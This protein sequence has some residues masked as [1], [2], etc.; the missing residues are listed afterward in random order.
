LVN[1]NK[2]AHFRISKSNRSHFE[3]ASRNSRV[4]KNSDQENPPV[5]T[6]AKSNEHKAPREQN[7]YKTRLEF[8]QGNVEGCTDLLPQC[9]TGSRTLLGGK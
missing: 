3:F 8:L 7:F 5:G 2:N 6:W 9:I 4:S 1:K